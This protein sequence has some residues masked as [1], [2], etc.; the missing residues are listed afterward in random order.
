M[1]SSK[2]KKVEVKT[3]KRWRIGYSLMCVCIWV[4][5]VDPICR[6]SRISGVTHGL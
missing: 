3:K 6:S 5:S 4:E 1:K 2:E